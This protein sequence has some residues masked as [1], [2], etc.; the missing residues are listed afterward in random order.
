MIFFPQ[1]FS[2]IQIIDDNLSKSTINAGRTFYSIPFICIMATLGFKYIY[3]Y[4]TS[5]SYSIRPV[6]IFLIF[7]IFCFRIYGYHSELK[8]FNI[9]IV[10]SYNI[11]FSQPAMV[12]NIEN[13]DQYSHFSLK[14][15]NQVYFYRMAKFVSNHLK[16]VTL[17][18][19]S[20][21]LLFIPAEI[22]TPNRYTN[23]SG[24]KKGYP[25]YFP[26]YLTFYLQEQGINVSYLVKKKDVKETFLKK[27]VIVLDRYKQGNNLPSDTLSA[28][29][30]PRTKTQE[31]I[32][33]M[34]VNIIDWIENY[35]RG[36]QWLDS[37]REQTHFNQNISSIGD[38][39]VNVTSSKTPDY[40]II[41]SNEE[42]DQ[43][44]DQ[45]NY[46]LVLSLPL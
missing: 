4:T 28:G 26:M 29:H 34:F 10:D 11:D 16:K 46:E 36:K 2:E 12:D 32:V 18:S 30:Y 33:K 1:L 43:I 3:T 41:T 22:Y 35:E 17:D 19:D 42:L 13:L 20:T 40:L 37:I 15:Y 44:R 25:Y 45:S 21:K 27:A 24:G 31:K 23:S 5:R 9:E 6:F 14:H 38:Y 39:F 8:R 7:L